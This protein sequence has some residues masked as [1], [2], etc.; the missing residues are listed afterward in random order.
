M[1]T[2]D[3]ASSVRRAPAAL[4]ASAALLAV[5]AACTGR[6]ETVLVS[7]NDAGSSDSGAAVGPADADALLPADAAAETGAVF[8]SLKGPDSCGAGWVCVGYESSVA[9]A[10]T[11][12]RRCGAGTGATCADTEYCYQPGANKTTACTDDA[13]APSV[14][15]VRWPFSSPPPVAVLPVC[16]CDGKTYTHAIFAAQ[17]G[18][19]V[20]YDGPCGVCTSDPE[21]NRD[22]GVSALKGACDTTVGSPGRCVCNPGATFD[23]PTGKCT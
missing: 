1:I 23:Q 19:N 10:G 7:S 11:C 3:L 2:V 14:C 8:C 18:I 22:T 13:S 4:V 5:V 20:R 17:T 16:G 12:M 6:L 9:G 21:C 15:R